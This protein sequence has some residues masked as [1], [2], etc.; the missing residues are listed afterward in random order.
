MFLTLPWNTAFR[1][2]AGPA[3][4]TPCAILGLGWA[5]WVGAWGGGVPAQGWQGDGSVGQVRVL[6]PCCPDSYG[7][8]LPPAPGIS[9]SGRD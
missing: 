1:R 7:W 4:P 5:V 9:T 6:E 3:L 8:S 2:R